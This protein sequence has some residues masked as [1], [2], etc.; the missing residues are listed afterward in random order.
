MTAAEVHRVACRF[1]P[2]IQ[3]IARGVC[4][5]LPASVEVSDLAQAGVVGML[6][7]LRSY[8]P[9]RG[10]RVDVYVTRRVRGAILDEL[11][12]LDPLSRDLRR[13]ARAIRDATRA[14]T[15]ELGRVPDDAEVGRRAGLGAERVALVRERLA[16]AAPV[17]LDAAVVAADLSRPDLDEAVALEEHRARLAAAVEGLPGRERMVLSL[18]YV[19]ELSLKEI[20]GLLGVTESRVCQIH[21][22]AV[23]KLRAALGA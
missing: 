15:G 1:L 8:D 10:D 5:Q 4:R 14:L 16:R 21:G 19:E 2:R 23:K 7:A 13:D 18:Y 12:A 20:G 3:K 11:R 22:G 6:G 9:R 17:P